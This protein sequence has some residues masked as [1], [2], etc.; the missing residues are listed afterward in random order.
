[1][2]RKLARRSHSH[3]RKIA[4]THRAP[5]SHYLVVVRGWMFLVAFAMMLGLGAMMGNFINAQ[6]NQSTPQ[7]AGA[8]TQK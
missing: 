1:M 8:S 3:P 6:L 7:V 2:K 4:H 5:S